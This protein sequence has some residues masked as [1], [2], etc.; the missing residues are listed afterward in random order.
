MS[1]RDEY[2]DNLIRRIKWLRLKADQE[3]EGLVDT[4]LKNWHKLSSE[5]RVFAEKMSIECDT[6]SE[7]KLRTTYSQDALP[8]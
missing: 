4:Y 1:L 8:G 7:Q 6:W 5:K 3:I 2:R